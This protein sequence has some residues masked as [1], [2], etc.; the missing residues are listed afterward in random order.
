MER[1]LKASNVIAV[2]NAHGSEIGFFLS[3]LKGSR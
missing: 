3:T 2:G 1:T